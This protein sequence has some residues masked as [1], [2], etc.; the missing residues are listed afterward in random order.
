VFQVSF[1]EEFSVTAVAMDIAKETSK[2]ATLANVYQ[3]VMEGW[4]C[5]MEDERCKPF[6]Q[7]KDQLSTDQWCLLW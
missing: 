6:Y 1:V 5:K 2:D 3:N 4:P 7:W